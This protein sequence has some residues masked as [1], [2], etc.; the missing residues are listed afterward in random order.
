M[1]AML[2]ARKLLSLTFAH[3]VALDDVGPGQGR[4]R[5]SDNAHR[6]RLVRSMRV[7]TTSQRFD[8][9]YYL[10]GE[11]RPLSSD[12]SSRLESGSFT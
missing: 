6:R 9:Q 3:V 1:S 11:P 10:P 12:F 4:L 2:V 8:G 5:R 7:N